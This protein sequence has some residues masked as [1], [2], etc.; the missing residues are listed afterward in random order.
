MKN[1][2]LTN[3][4]TFSWSSFA[5]SSQVWYA[6]EELSSYTHFSP[7]SGAAKIKKVSDDSLHSS[8][9][10]ADFILPFAASLF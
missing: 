5:H 4:Q 9:I 3:Q 10:P 2:K 8:T 6:S 7:K 1:K